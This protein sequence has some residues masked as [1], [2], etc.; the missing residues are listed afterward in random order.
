M[1]PTLLYEIAQCFKCFQFL[2]SKQLWVQ[3]CFIIT[4]FNQKVIKTDCHQIVIINDFDQIVIITDFDQIVYIELASSSY[5][6]MPTA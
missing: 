4:D 6:R 5:N 1:P 3:M 2:N